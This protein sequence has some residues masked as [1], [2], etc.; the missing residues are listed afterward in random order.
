MNKQSVSLVD[1]AEEKSF[2]EFLPQK[3]L[4]YLK[5]EGKRLYDLIIIGGGPAG[6][7]AAIYAA[8]ERQR[9]LL[10][11]RAFYGGQIALTSEVEN[12]PGVEKISGPELAEI[13]RSQAE[14]F[15][16]EFLEKEVVKI[17]SFDN[18]CLK[19]LSCDDGSE[20]FCLQLICATGAQ[21]RPAGFDGE[22]KFKGS[23]VSYCATCDG[24]FYTDKE[25]YVIGGGFA[26]CEES[27]YLTKFAR[28]LHMIIRRDR[29]S[30]PE[31]ITQ[32]VL[33]H[34]QIE[35][36]FNTR[37]EAL[38]GESL[39]SR[40]ILN[41]TQTQE[42]E[43]LDKEVGSFGV[44][45]FTGYDP[46]SSLIQDLVELDAYKGAISDKYM[47]TNVA[48]V[49]TAGDVRG[50]QLRQLVTA[51][52]DGAIAATSAG[53]VLSEVKALYPELEN[54]QVQLDHESFVEITEQPQRVKKSSAS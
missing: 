48:G 23:G 10:I 43:I 4:A 41:N 40:I 15:G 13:M 27:L 46:E 37:I 39:P 11:E 49:Y 19:K 2:E 29:F 54:I 50:K 9:V 21:P 7:S 45:V 32:Q 18:S 14:N 26:A 6:L 52:S 25:I 3:S 12:Y 38:E 33:A 17:E 22:E 20:Y 5:H 53:K 31:S 30:A 36:H 34:P 47:A 1:V 28:K 42:K 51:A 35:V 44:F 8:R 16:C 24:K